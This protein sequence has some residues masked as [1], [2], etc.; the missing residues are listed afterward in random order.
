M[1]NGMRA[2][3]LFEEETLRKEC[4]ALHRCEEMIS[5]LGL[6]SINETKQDI[7]TTNLKYIL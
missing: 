7:R 4:E 1:S 3:M 6:F 2:H 5:K